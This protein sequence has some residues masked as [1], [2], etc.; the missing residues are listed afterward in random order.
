[1]VVTYFMVISQFLPGQTKVNYE[2]TQ[3]RTN[4]TGS[5][6]PISETKLNTHLATSQSNRSYDMPNGMATARPDVILI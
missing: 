1:M 4:A 6:K 5:K 2:V 3:Y